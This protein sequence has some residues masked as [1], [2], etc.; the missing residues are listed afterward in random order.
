MIERD[1]LE[2]RANLLETLALARMAGSKKGAAEV[3]KIIKQWREK[4]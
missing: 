4:V 1:E 3:E 2:E